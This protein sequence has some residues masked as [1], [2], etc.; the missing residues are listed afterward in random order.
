MEGQRH[1]GAS[2][3]SSS[4]SDACALGP[5]RRCGG[6]IGAAGHESVA[7]QEDSGGTSTNAAA[8]GT[9][10]GHRADGDDVEGSGQTTIT[11]ATDG[12]SDEVVEGPR[13][14]NGLFVLGVEIDQRGEA[15]PCEVAA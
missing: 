4:S 13:G 5:S 6:I 3:S 15:G 2:S 1:S 8:G 10:I 12:S 11:A 7:G 9:G 14:R